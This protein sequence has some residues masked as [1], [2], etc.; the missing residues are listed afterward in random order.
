MGYGNGSAQLYPVFLDGIHAELCR[1]SSMSF[2]RKPNRIIIRVFF[3]GY[4]LE[5]CMT[6]VFAGG[7]ND[8]F[9]D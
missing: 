8:S 4:V 3:S 5:L 9:Q 2:I 6:S 7:G 1:N